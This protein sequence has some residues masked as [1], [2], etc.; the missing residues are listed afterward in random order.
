MY[1]F[2][3]L[4]ANQNL[5]FRRNSW[6]NYLSFVVIH[7]N[8]YIVYNEV[9]HCLF[10]QIFQSSQRI[11]MHC[12]AFPIPTAGITAPCSLL[13]NINILNQTHFHIDQIQP[14]VFLHQ[15][16]D[17]EYIFIK[18]LLYILTK[19]NCVLI[20]FNSVIMYVPTSQ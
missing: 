5:V 13:L 20:Y 2:G 15:F 16:I 18:I 8:L 3:L 4:K 19:I 12:C 9:F 7:K 11:L 10:T 6:N 1:S 17:N 14:N